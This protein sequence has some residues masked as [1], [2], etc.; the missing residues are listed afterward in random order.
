[1]FKKIRKIMNKKNVVVDMEKQ[2]KEEM[3]KLV[4]EDAGI[5]IGTSR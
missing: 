2:E 5:M 4:A 3:A 1:M